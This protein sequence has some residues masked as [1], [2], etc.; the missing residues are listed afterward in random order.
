MMGKLKLELFYKAKEL[1]ADED[2]K[3]H[4]VFYEKKEFEFKDR[5]ELLD[6]MDAMK[7]YLWKLYGDEKIEV[8]NWKIR[9]E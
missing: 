5:E 2:F 9:S 7:I 6:M 3:G 8:R 4:D 1:S